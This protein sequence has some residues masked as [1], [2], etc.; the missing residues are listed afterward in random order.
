MGRPTNL[1]RAAT[2]ISN[3]IRWAEQ[4]RLHNIAAELHAVLAL[5]N[6][7]AGKTDR[8][9]LRRAIDALRPD[10]HSDGCD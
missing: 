8:A 5:L 2:K 7:E 3:M 6:E 4:Q 1:E 9:Q 10:S